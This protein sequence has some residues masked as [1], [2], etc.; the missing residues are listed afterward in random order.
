MTCTPTYR[1]N[2]FP[3]EDEPDGAVFVDVKTGGMGYIES[4]GKNWPTSLERNNWRARLG[5]DLDF[6][7]PTGFQ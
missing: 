3:A 1:G 2:R 7:S 4:L 6:R 5:R